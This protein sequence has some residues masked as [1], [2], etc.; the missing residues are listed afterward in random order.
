[1]QISPIKQSY[2]SIIEFDNPMDFFNQDPVFWKNML[3]NKN[4]LIFKKMNFNIA[5]YGRFG[6]AF[7]YPWK[8]EYYK[9][10]NEATE[11]IT[12]GSAEYALST[13]SNSIKA[14]TRIRNSEMPWHADIPN[15]QIY[16]FPHRTL[17]IVKNPNPTISGKTRW[18]NIEVGIEYL[19][20][21][22]KDLA[23]RMSVLQQSWYKPGTD[24][25][26]YD[27]IKIHPITGRKSL[28]LNFY[29]KPGNEDAWILKTYID[30]IEQPDNSLIQLFIDH[31]LQY[32]ELLYEHTWDDYDIAIYDNYAFIH[33][34]SKLVFTDENNSERKFYRMNINHFNL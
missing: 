31:L 16:P 7:G 4:I 5:D 30:G 21:S 33:G 23:D 17:W 27:F 22:L 12:D 14:D 1:M 24:T 18:L 9:Y 32:D 13:F 29:V 15:H 26:M 8:E 6:T 34:R 25:H 19:N 28:R 11:I 20:E 2:G 10:S 3:Y